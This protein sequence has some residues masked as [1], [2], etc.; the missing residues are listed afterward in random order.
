MLSDP[1]LAHIKAA[2]EDIKMA[3]TRGG[4]TPGGPFF[5]GDKR[6]LFYRGAP[7]KGGPRISNEARQSAITRR[8]NGGAR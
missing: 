1:S 6:K 8:L 2:Q 4:A 3:Q 7:K 5:G